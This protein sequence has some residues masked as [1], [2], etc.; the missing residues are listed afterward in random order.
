MGLVQW[1]SADCGH[2]YIDYYHSNNWYRFQRD[3]GTAQDQVVEKS[4]GY[5]IT[6]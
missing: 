4:D 6:L 1:L 5:L 2:R 3:Q